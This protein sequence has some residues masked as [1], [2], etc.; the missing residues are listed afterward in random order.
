MEVIT[1]ETIDRLLTHYEVLFAQHHLVS[2]YLWL[3]G[4]TSF[5]KIIVSILGIPSV[6]SHERLPFFANS[7]DLIVFVSEESK[8]ACQANIDPNIPTTIFPNYFTES[9]L[10]QKPIEKNKLSKIAVISNHAPKE[11]RNLKSSLAKD[12]VQVDFFGYKDKSVEI[13]D[14]FIKQYD[15][16]I[17]IGRTAQCC[18]AAKIPYYCYDHFGG[19]GYITLENVEKHAYSNFSG[20]SEPSKK[21]DADL[22]LDILNGYDQ[23]VENL[24]KLQGFALQNFSL[25]SNFARLMMQI[26]EIEAFNKARTTTSESV[27]QDIFRACRKYQLEYLRCLGTCQL[28]YS[29]EDQPRAICEENS[30]KLKYRY[31]TQITIDTNKLC[32][33]NE[34]IVRID[35]DEKSCICKIEAKGATPI[36]GLF[37]KNADGRDIFLSNDPS[38]SVL[39]PRVISFL[40]EPIDNPALVIEKEIERLHQE[41]STLREKLLVFD[42]RHG[43][44]IALAKNLILLCSRRIVS[45]LVRFKS[46]L[47]TSPQAEKQEGISPGYSSRGHHQ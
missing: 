38:Y 1:P 35:P 27:R 13:T 25:S 14:G 36:S 44:T 41:N 3:F 22:R 19:P 32:K 42:S 6:T 5:G 23:A 47:K 15:L 11:V 21:S 7:A 34:S 26:D 4:N 30:I 31:N 24:D 40:V 10:E 28:F 8:A 12:N 9:F 45:S 37:E 39:K 18:F 17:S 20:R 16:V 29:S 43:S 46:F 33:K 2:E